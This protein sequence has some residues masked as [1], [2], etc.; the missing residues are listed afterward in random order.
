MLLMGTLEEQ[1]F[2]ILVKSNLLAFCFTV[3]DFCVLTI[4]FCLPQVWKCLWYD[5]LW[6]NFAHGIKQEQGIIPVVYLLTRVQRFWDPM[7]CSLPGSSV[8]RISQTRILE[9][10]AISF[11]RGS[12]WARDWTR[13]SCI[14]RWV[15]CPEPAGKPRTILTMSV[16][17][18]S[19]TIVWKGCFFLHGIIFSSLLMQ[20]GNLCVDLVLLSVLSPCPECLSACRAQWLLHCKSSAKASPCVVLLFYTR[21]I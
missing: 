6:A 20:V 19:G 2:Y 16:S 3:C 15:L 17:I 1:T 4:K 10:V 5:P 14:C 11:S 7:D 8:H 21:L 18:C 13:V 12:S 9:W